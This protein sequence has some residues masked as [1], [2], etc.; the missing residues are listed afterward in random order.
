MAAKGG[1]AAVMVG[2]KAA[3][4]GTAEGYQIVGEETVSSHL[5]VEMGVTKHTKMAK[6][7]F[8]NMAVS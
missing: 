5:S 8:K 7:F 1:A 3:A 6:I 4:E 2:N